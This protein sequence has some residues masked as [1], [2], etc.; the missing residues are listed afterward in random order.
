[1]KISIRLNGEPRE[2]AEGSTVEALVGLLALTKGRV[3]VERN[4]EIVPMSAWADVV[5]AEGDE[6]EI[7]HFVGG[8]MD[9]GPDDSW[10]VAGRTFRSRLI[11]GTGKYRDYPD[12]YK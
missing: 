7:V 1:M 4:R 9:G 6:V 5:L 2:L 10:T 8:G 11:V 3:A 12:T